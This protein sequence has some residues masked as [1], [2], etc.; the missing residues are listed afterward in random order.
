MRMKKAT[1]AF[2]AML[3]QTTVRNYRQAG[4][5][6]KRSFRACFARLF[7]SPL[8]EDMLDKIGGSST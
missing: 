4:I 8:T 7:D 6:A 2:A 3:R 1:V 5:P